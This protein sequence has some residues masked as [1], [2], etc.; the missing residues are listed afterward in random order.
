MLKE[1]TKLP[2]IKSVISK[3]NT[4]KRA[5]EKQDS[6]DQ[7]L[8][9]KMLLQKKEVYII[10]LDNPFLFIVFCLKATVCSVR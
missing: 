8:V 3:S 4:L 9:R 6:L 2:A 1:K 7:L 10:S 5:A